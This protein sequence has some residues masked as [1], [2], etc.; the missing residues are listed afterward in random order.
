MSEEKDSG[1]PFGAGPASVGSRSAP[2]P[3]GC[4]QKNILKNARYGRKVR[5]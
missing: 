2:E 5:A 4:S 1:Q 3:S